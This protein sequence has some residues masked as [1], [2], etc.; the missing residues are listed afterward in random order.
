MNNNLYRQPEIG[1]NIKEMFWDLMSQW[2][3]VLIVAVI[4]AA[5]V[6][7]AK[8]QRDSSLYKESITEKETTHS[9]IPVDERVDIILSSLSNEDASTV[10]FLVKQNEWI[11]NEKEYMNNSIL[12][13]TNPSNQRTLVLDYCISV[14]DYTEAKMTALMYGYTGHL[15]NEEL[16]NSVGQAIA[17]DI[18]SKYI[19]EL[20][21]INSD[22]S[23]VQSGNY[24]LVTDSDSDSAI[25]EVRIVLPSD[26][27]ATKVQQALTTALSDFKPELSDKIGGHSIRLVS[28]AEVYLFNN[29][30]VTNHNNMMTA[31]Y[32]LQNNS[33]NMRNMLSEEQ[34]EALDSITAINKESSQPIDSLQQKEPETEN[35]K[36]VFSKKYAL[37]GFVMGAMLYAFVYA[38]I[39][40]V[41][42]RI[43]YACD[44]AHYTQAR[45]LGE[46]YQKTK[47][48]GVYALLHSNF[49]NKYRYKGKMDSDLQ[50]EK[51]TDILEA[52][53]K[54][55]DVQ[56]VKLYNMTRESNKDVLRKVLKRASEK[57]VNIKLIEIED[58]IDELNLLHSP[59]V[60]VAVEPETKVSK[61]IN[62]A[63]IFNEYDVKPIGCVFIGTI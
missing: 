62:M 55:G 31:I 34:K 7:G 3:A 2:K 63:A 60:V 42:G 56:D 58:D 32:N 54:H 47:H 41:R 39:M 14:S 12:M 48:K 20:I 27:D 17:P 57:G 40:I 9:E 11:E 52:V 36:P 46:V 22:N 29:V 8:Y 43:S 49:V 26:A 45:L 51:A 16:I 50:I 44:A 18:S 25:M 30:A 19:A 53:C 59:H 13:N 21:S 10:E 37:L 5:I 33:K 28:S 24:N 35:V 61:A 23:G 38:V 15:S 1:I 6:T 4:V